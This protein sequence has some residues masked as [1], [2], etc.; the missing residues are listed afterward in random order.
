MRALCF[1]Q[2]RG[3]FSF[4]GLFSM[5][6]KSKPLPRPLDF[7]DILFFAYLSLL[8]LKNSFAKLLYA[9]VPLLNLEKY[10]TGLPNPGASDNFTARGIT[11]LNT[12][13]GKFFFTSSATCLVRF[14]LKSH[15]VIKIPSNSNSELW[16][17]FT[18]FI[19]FMSCER[20]SKA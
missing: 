20:P 19:V 13:S 2:R 10:A 6:L 1:R 17:L 4:S 14:N 18:T 9:N 16:C 12:F 8:F 3:M 5:K 15:I 11:V 7:A